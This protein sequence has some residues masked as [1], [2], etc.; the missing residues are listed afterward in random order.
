MAALIGW[1][2]TVR[3]RFVPPRELF[4]LDL[5]VPEQCEWSS[6]TEREGSHKVEDKDLRLQLLQ[7]D[8]AHDSGVPIGPGKS[9]SV[10]KSSPPGRNPAFRRSE[11]EL[12]ASADFHAQFGHAHM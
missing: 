10:Y 1:R 7:D 12:T 9:A 4:G 8:S 6:G 11:A 2:P 5:S 3:S